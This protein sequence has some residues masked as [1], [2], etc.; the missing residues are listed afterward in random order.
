[1]LSTKPVDIAIQKIDDHP[2][3][4]LIRNNSTLSDMS[5]FGSVFLDAILKEIKTLNSVKNVFFKNIPTHCL[6]EVVDIFIS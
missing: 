4:K 1:M 5:E 3:I 6:K 2:S